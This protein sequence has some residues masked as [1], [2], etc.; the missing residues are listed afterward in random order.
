MNPGCGLASRARNPTPTPR[1]RNARTTP[2]HR[3]RNGRVLSLWEKRKNQRETTIPPQKHHAPGAHRL[4]GL[5]SRVTAFSAVPSRHGHFTTESPIRSPK[6]GRKPKRRL[7]AA[8]FGLRPPPPPPPRMPQ[9][10]RSPPPVDTI[11]PELPKTPPASSCA[12]RHPYPLRS[13]L[14][15]RGCHFGSSL[16]VRILL[17]PHPAYDAPPPSKNVKDFPVDNLLISPKPNH[18]PKTRRIPN[19]FKLFSPYLCP[20]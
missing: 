16:P 10:A 3:P 7:A 17:I 15:L 2:T 9:A 1:P 4:R 14:E 5:P 8:F 6:S 19:L 11:R 12:F 18:T 13:I 20:I